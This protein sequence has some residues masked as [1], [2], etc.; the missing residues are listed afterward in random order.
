MANQYVGRVIGQQVA[1]VRRKSRGVILEQAQILNHLVHLAQ[2]SGRLAQM[3]RSSA[4]TKLASSAQ[5]LAS[6]AGRLAKA[7]GRHRAQ[8]L[9]AVG[10]TGGTRKV[11]AIR[12]ESVTLT[13]GYANL[14]LASGHGFGTARGP[15]KMVAKSRLAKAQA[16]LAAARRALSVAEMQFSGRRRQ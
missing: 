6:C 3:A 4:D 2:S 9:V 12:S 11:S 1:K 7:I 16:R 8:I 15:V 10:Q 14:G 5:T 13:S